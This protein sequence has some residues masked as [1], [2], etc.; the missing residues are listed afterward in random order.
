MLSAVK[1]GFPRFLV[2]LKGNDANP[3]RGQVNRESQALARFPPE[4]AQAAI[5]LVKRVVSYTRE[6]KPI[7][8]PELL[9]EEG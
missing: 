6:S 8:V 4:T 5:V 7:S 3:V 9:S 1:R 2:R